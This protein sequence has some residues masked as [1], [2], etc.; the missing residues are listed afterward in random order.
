MSQ[1]KYK[2]IINCGLT[3]LLVFLFSHCRLRNTTQLALLTNQNG[4]YFYK[5]H[6]ATLTLLRKPITSTHVHLRG[7]ESKLGLEE[8]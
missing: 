2:Q 6:L 1:P 7:N 4:R 3:I 8:A 5:T